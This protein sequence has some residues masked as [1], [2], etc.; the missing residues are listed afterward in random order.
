MLDVNSHRYMC[1]WHDEVHVVE[2]DSIIDIEEVVSNHL[3]GV[4]NLDLERLGDTFLL[5][6]CSLQCIV[7]YVGWCGCSVPQCQLDSTVLVKGLR[8][9]LV[10]TI[11]IEIVL[12]FRWCVG[13]CILNQSEGD[14]VSSDGDV[15]EVLVNITTSSDFIP[16]P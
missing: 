10:D 6:V 1:T 16:C 2:A 14:V 15:F 12:L 8:W 7:G 13:G 11:V 4:V 5:V 9:F 3:T